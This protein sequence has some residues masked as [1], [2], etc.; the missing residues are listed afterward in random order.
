LPEFRHPIS[1]LSLSFQCLACGLRDASSSTESRDGKNAATPWL[2]GS[3]NITMTLR[4]ERSVRQGITVFALSGRMN[5]EGVAELKVLFDADYR[6]IILDLRDVRL[7]D[8]DA[9]RFLKG[10][11]AEGMQL[12][13]CPA[14]VREWMD[15]EKD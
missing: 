3:N 14:Y 6:N 4:I 5:A 8:R 1:P 9:V 13:N 7:A 12:E 11:E 10:C 2:T 15:R